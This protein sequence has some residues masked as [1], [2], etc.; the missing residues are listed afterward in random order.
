[1][2]LLKIQRTMDPTAV[3]AVSGRLDG[4][5]VR[6]L[7]QLI[8]AEPPGTPVVVDFTDL[9]LADRDAVRYLRDCETLDRVVFRNC[10]EYVRVWMTAEENR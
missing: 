2:A 9:I 10:P 5:N 3:F 6:E 1:V 8:D 4:E 7:C